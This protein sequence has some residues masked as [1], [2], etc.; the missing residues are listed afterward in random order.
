M[1]SRTPTPLRCPDCVIWNIWRPIIP[2][3]N[4]TD[5]GGLCFLCQ[6]AVAA[7]PVEVFSFATKDE[8][9]S[10][11]I[12]QV[13]TWLDTIDIM[14]RE[15]A[16]LEY[17]LEKRYAAIDDRIQLT[18]EYGP[19]SQGLNIPT[20]CWN[21]LTHLQKREQIV[22]DEERTLFGPP[23]SLALFYRTMQRD[24]PRLEFMLDHLRD[25]TYKPLLRLWEERHEQ[26]S[27]VYT[28]RT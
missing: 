25:R 26:P 13:Q 17:G 16:I 27:G 21:T 19:I 7:N 3:W 5:R 10:K 23:M 15:A 12:D 9:F 4:A 2:A 22:T 11:K 1:S 8:M 18:D 14:L 20:V 28:G 6:Q 24:K